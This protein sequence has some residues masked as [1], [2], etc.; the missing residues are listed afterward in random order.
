M[1]ERLAH[2]AA[3]RYH[4]IPDSTRTRAGRWCL[5]MTD[6]QTIA[7]AIRAIRQPIHL[8][9]NGGRYTLVSPEQFAA[10]PPGARSAYAPACR[11]EDLGDPSF[12]ADHRLRYPYVAGAMANGIGSADIVEAMGRAGMLAFFG[13]AGLPVPT[14]EAAIDRIQKNLGAAS[15]SR[16]HAPRGNESRSTP[17]GFNLIHSPGEPSLERAVVDLYL[18]RGVRLVEASAFLDLTLPVVRYRLHG[19]H[20]DPSGR[21]VTPNRVIV[22]VSRVEVASKFLAPPP[23]RMLQELIRQ[24]DLTSDQAALAARVPVAQDV[25]A[26]ADS[27]GHTDNRPAITLIPTLIALRDRLLDQYGYDEPLRVG[28]AGGI[29]TPASAAAAFAMG[30]AYVLTG[31]INQACVESGSSDAVREMLAQAEQADTI[32]A[33]AAD[34]FEMGVK[35]QVLKRGT[36]FAMRAAKLYELYRNYPSLEALPDAERTNLEKNLFRAPLT[37][38]WDKTRAFFRER[39]P[40][41]LARAE[42]EAKHKMALVF[43]WYLGLS[44]RWANAGEPTRRLDY[45]VWCGPA[46]GAFNEW[47]KGSFLEQP[48]QRRVVP[49]AFNILYGAAVLLRLQTLRG[50][51]LPLLRDWARLTPLERETIEA[52]METD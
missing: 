12:C 49:V 11:L 5:P 52:L 45:Q 37:E 47:T 20:R 23:D 43:R 3:S 42:R 48:R 31:S 39:D 6:A 32:M 29:A 2:R 19:I 35:V 44:S 34:M 25:T 7:E 24:G 51:G 28:A 13:A 50:Q 9:E 41:Q 4:D 22:K 26:E 36:M 1:Q 8:V 16:S 33:P 21:I 18:R 30:A 14:V 15:D 10:P 46:M 17:Y 38:I 40:S 27:G